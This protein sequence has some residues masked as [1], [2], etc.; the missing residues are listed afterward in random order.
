M[1]DACAWHTID[2]GGFSFL[3]VDLG[4][5][6]LERLAGA[7]QGTQDC[8]P[9]RAAGDTNGQKNGKDQTGIWLI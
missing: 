8:E 1:A 4:T 2:D 7:Q 3:G 9:W 5:L 6:G